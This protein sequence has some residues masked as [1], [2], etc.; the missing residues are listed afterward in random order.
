MA[1]LVVMMLSCLLATL[2]QSILKATLLNVPGVG[3]G[4]YGDSDERS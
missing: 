2:P 3:V 1:I 4:G